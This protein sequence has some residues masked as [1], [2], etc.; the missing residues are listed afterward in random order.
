[1][2]I[3]ARHIKFLHS[4]S[5]LILLDGWQEGH[6]ACMIITLCQSPEVLCWQTLREHGL[7]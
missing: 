7:T 1:M 5:A 2:L 6:P 4:F 3:L